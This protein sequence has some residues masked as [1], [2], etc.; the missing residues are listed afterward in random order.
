VVGASFS[1]RENI[2]WVKFLSL[3]NTLLM[4][5]SIGKANGHKPIA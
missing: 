1:E 5:T 3:Y 2:R 4:A